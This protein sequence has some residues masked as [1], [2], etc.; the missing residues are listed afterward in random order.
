[1]DESL[2]RKY[3]GDVDW[4]HETKKEDSPDGQPHS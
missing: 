4:L 1:M 2:V 3:Y